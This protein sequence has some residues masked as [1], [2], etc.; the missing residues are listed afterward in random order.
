VPAPPVPD[1]EPFPE[2][3]PAD[4]NNSAEQQKIAAPAMRVFTIEPGFD[5][6]PP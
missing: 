1:D 5:M 3:H 2:L 6:G 4:D